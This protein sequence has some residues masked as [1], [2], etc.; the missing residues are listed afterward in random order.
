MRC[1]PIC[2][3]HGGPAG[4]ALVFTRMAD[5][6]LR[7]STGNRSRGA[8]LP[9]DGLIL[10]RRETTQLPEDSVLVAVLLLQ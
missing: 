9:E 5:E 4:V 8:D 2:Q 6:K 3:V 10:N 7:Q 1:Q